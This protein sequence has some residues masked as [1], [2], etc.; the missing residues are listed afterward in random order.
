MGVRLAW[1]EI[2]G[3]RGNRRVRVFIER[4]DDAVGLG[5][6]ERMNERLSALCDLEDPIPGSWTLEVSTPGLDRPLFSLEE[7]R[8][9]VGR[10][11][12]VRHLEGDRP[13]AVTGTLSAVEEGAIR[14]TAGNP[15]R[16]T[17]RPN[18]PANSPSD[19]RPNSQ[20]TSGSGRRAPK[21]SPWE[22]RIEWSRVQRAKL[23]PDFDALL[24][25][26][27]GEPGAGGAARNPD[28]APGGTARPG[29]EPAPARRS[30]A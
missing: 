22:S 19:S 1:T 12:T 10:R 2:K 4:P 30:R 5:D 27:R 17:P 13:K 9:F 24:R 28:R 23:A 18:S 8:R 14:L 3:S 26:T 16:R 25:G 21:E 15:A 29:S 7:C 20:K 11:V 6:C